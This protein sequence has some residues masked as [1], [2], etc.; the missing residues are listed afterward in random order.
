MVK[1]T[2]MYLNLWKQFHI[3][4]LIP[5]P[6]GPHHFSLFAKTPHTQ[7][8]ILCQQI[9]RT[10]KKQLNQHFIQLKRTHTHTLLPYTYKYLYVMQNGSISC[11]NSALHKTHLI[12]DVY[13]LSTEW[14]FIKSR[15]SPTH[16]APSIYG[17]AE[18]MQKHLLPISIG[19]LCTTTHIVH[20]KRQT[21]L[22][23]MCIA[24]RECTQEAIWFMIQ[25]GKCA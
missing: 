25:K 4:N 8:F 6:F 1:F 19:A 12:R 23:R 16:R 17:A 2:I 10:D 11:S 21:R 24:I 18:Y 13:P 22:P 15:T 3:V 20:R 14:W 9:F 7:S 5:P